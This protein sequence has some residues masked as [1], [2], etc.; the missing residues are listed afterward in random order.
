LSW[1]HGGGPVA[2]DAGLLRLVRQVDVQKRA[3]AVSASSAAVWYRNRHRVGIG[4]AHRLLEQEV[5]AGTLDARWTDAHHAV[6]W[7]Y[8][9]PTSL[10]NVLLACAYHHSELH[11]PDGWTVFIAPDG[12][13][14]FIPKRVDPLQRPQRNRFHRRQ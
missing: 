10:D 11:K 5:G 6:H 8:G 13:P 1:R 14:T 3:S 2:R 7:A 12:L 4:G 9:G